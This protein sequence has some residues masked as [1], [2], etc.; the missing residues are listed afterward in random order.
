MST[1]D[2]AETVGQ[3]EAVIDALFAAWL[4]FPDQ[5][6]GQFLIN[7]VAR[8]D[9]RASLFY[10]EDFELL[11]MAEAYVATHGTKEGKGDG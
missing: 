9:I 8:A 6:L 11:R 4:R 2:R 3:K 5:R 1:D 7:A 10:V